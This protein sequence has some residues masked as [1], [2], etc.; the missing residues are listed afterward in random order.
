MII[1]YFR[2]IYDLREDHDFTQKKVA[3]YLGLNPTVY[4]RYEKGVRD[5]P[6]DIILKL[7]DLYRVS[8]DYLLGRT[9]VPTP[10]PPSRKL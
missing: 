4:R 6:I 10:P 7:A 9:D 5:F 8:T 1:L 2:R 3:E